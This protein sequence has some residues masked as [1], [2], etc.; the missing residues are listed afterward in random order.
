MSPRYVTNARLRELEAQLTEL[1]ERLLHQAAVLRFVTGNQLARMHFPNRDRQASAR[2]ARRALLRLVRLGLLARLPRAVGGV[3]SGSAGFIY[4]LSSA[5]QR[6]AIK[7]GWQAGHGRWR[8]HVP[9][10]LFLAHALKVAELHTLLIEANR[11]GRLELLALEAEPVC[12]RKYGAAG[13]QRTLKPDSYLQLGIGDY[14]DSYFIEIDMGTEGSRAVDSKL[15]QYV[16]YAASG[17]ARVVIPKA[18]W[19]VPDPE[20]AEAVNA[21]IERL[22]PPERELFAVAEFTEVLT[23]LE[24]P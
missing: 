12:W 18:L 23:V 22:S 4:R 5:G 8:S 1:D 16:A 13:E 11:A 3:H 2:A 10:M 7:R 15:A 14:E 19:L 24:N 6:L 20:R 21:C 9:G 17:S